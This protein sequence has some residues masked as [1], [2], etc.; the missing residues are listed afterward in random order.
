MR[1]VDEHRRVVAALITARPPIAVALSDALGLVLA[2]DVVATLSLPGFDNSAMDGY[3]VF[4]DDIAGASDDEPVSLPVAE[5][6]PAGR[7]DPLTLK[8]GTAHRIM[9]GA[10]LPSGAGP[11]SITD[12]G[13]PGTAP[14]PAVGGSAVSG[15]SAFTP[16]G[17]TTFSWQGPNQAT[18]GST[19]TIALAIQPDQP[20][21]SVPFSV[22]Y[23]PKLFAVTTVTEGDFMRQGGA[24]SAFASRIDAAA[25][26]VFAT[27]SRSTPDGA[28][29][30]GTLATVT[31]RA[32]AP[33]PSA[34]VQLLASS[35]V[36]VG[37]R[38]VNAQTAPPYTVVIAP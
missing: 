36:G 1:S 4:A 33:A 3:A 6:I 10:P 32:L 5:D 18:I 2:D 14:S 25:G 15:P 9:T 17:S 23:D 35:P 11:S 21:T 34:T 26:R 37:G 27:V 8:P 30:P 13:V 16:S 24:Q 28:S 20:L 7:T 22:G 19:F 12:P 38:V 31:L 29:A